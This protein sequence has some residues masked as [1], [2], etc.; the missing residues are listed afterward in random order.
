MDLLK[1]AIGE[2]RANVISNPRL[3]ELY[4][5]FLK[6]SEVP[7]QQLKQRKLARPSPDKVLRVKRSSTGP[8]VLV[9]ANAPIAVVLRFALMEAPSLQELKRMLRNP[10]PSTSSNESV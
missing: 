9:P 10:P 8:S 6:Q 2:R 1:K 5:L 3:K 7:T 4:L